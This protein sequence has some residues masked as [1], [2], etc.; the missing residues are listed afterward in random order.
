MVT[1]RKMQ[2]KINYDGAAFVPQHPERSCGRKSAGVESFQ[3]I[4]DIGVGQTI[5]V[6]FPRIFVATETRREFV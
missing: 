6:Q 4:R 1:R 3:Q 5:F 2:D